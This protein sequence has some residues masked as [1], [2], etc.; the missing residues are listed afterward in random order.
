MILTPKSTVSITIL[1]DTV[2]NVEHLPLSTKIVYQK[3]RSTSHLWRQ[4]DRI[5]HPLTEQQFENRFRVG[6]RV[7]MRILNPTTKVY[8]NFT[9]AHIATYNSAKAFLGPYNRSDTF[10]G[11]PF[12]QALVLIA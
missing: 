8:V 9:I 6:D 10:K 4:Q 2:A 5:I 12:T 3:T 11:F 1:M 7:M